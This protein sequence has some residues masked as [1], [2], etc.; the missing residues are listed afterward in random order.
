MKRF[1]M[2]L[3]IMGFMALLPSQAQAV[4]IVDTGDA[5]TAG[6]YTLA[7]S[8][9]LAGSF[10][11]SQGH[12][13]TDVEGWMIQTTGDLS[14]VIFGTNGSVP[15]ETDEIFRQT[16]SVTG[17]GNT[18][19]WSGTHGMSL[20]LAPGS[21]WVGFEVLQGMTYNGHMPGG[22]ADPLDN[23]AFKP[24]ATFYRSLG[25][26]SSFPFGVRIQADGGNG[27]NAV[28]EPATMA[29]FGSGLVGVFLRKRKFV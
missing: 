4:F 12:T 23:Y 28:P 29:L 22:V 2:I 11:T 26:P 9:W 3:G 15:D 1:L 21:Y 25:T 7:S 5:G 16:F 19:G 24:S 27:P 13:I 10:T 20:S 8:Q 6:G 14:L 17:I 18:A